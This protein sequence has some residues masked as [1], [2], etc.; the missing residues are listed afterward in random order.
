MIEEEKDPL[1]TLREEWRAYRAERNLRLRRF[2]VKVMV[3]FAILGI[4]M[5]ATV[6]YVYCNAQK[7][8]D[9]L[10]SIRHDSERRVKLGEDFLEK[11]PN[12]TA[13]ISA[14]VLQRSVNSSKE[15]ARSLASLDC[16]LTPVLG[17]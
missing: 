15:T 7:N 11:H 1:E 16:D 14:D 8:T 10:C 17:G 2:F 5:S 9:A 13:D 6:G 12:G 4:T 3:I